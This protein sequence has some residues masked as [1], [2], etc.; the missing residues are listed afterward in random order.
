[1]DAFVGLLAF[2]ASFL[3]GS[4]MADLLIAVF[5]RRPIRAMAPSLT[6]TVIAATICA[7]LLQAPQLLGLLAVFF[8]LLFLIGAVL[9][10]SRRRFRDLVA[11]ALD[12]DPDRPSAV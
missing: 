5:E 1:M 3:L 8:A 4:L 9:D 2:I 6:V 12:P 11:E 7:L 10:R